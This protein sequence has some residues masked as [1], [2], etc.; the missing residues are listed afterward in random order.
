MDTLQGQGW[1]REAGPNRRDHRQVR[2]LALQAQ[3]KTWLI[4]GFNFG[5]G[6]LYLD[7][8]D[9]EKPEEL[10]SDLGTGARSAA[11]AFKMPGKQLLGVR[12][13]E[14]VWVSPHDYETSDP[15]KPNWYNAPRLVDLGVEGPSA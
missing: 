1:S 9:T 8:G 15:L 10:K 4:H 7:T 2:A 6:H 13:I 11:S 5:R 12:P 14:P 3:V